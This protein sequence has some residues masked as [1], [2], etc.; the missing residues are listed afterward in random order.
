MEELLYILVAFVLGFGFQK[1]GLPPLLGYLAG[2]FLLAG[3]G[4]TSTQTIEQLAHIGVIFLLF[5]LGLKIR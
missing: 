4:Y 2:G 1:I 5:T 3:F